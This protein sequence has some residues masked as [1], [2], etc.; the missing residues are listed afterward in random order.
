M[1]DLTPDP[2][3]TDKVTLAPGG[4]IDSVISSQ[5]S[6]LNLTGGFAPGTY[7]PTASSAINQTNNPTNS[8]STSI[9]VQIPNRSADLEAGN[10]LNGYIDVIYNI[11]LAM[12]S[13]SAVDQIRQSDVQ[14]VNVN[15]DQY[16]V[17]ASTAEAK[18]NSTS[19]FQ[20]GSLGDT[21]DLN[22]TG[23]YY[24]IEG[25]TFTSFLGHLPQN[26]IVA[27]IWD[28]LLKM[29]EPYGFSFREDIA[30]MAAQLG[31]PAELSPI[32]YVYRLE[33][34][35]SGYDPVSGN[36]TSR[37][38]IPCPQP[39]NDDNKIAS[40]SIVYYLVITTCEAKVTPT[41]T[42]YDLSFQTVGHYATRAEVI[43]LHQDNVPKG[44]TEIAAKTGETFRQFLQELANRLTQQVSFDTQHKLTI[45]YQF[46]GFK[47]LLDAK[48]IADASVNFSTGVT[49]NTDS[50]S[51][52]VAAKN[53][54]LYTLVNTVMGNLQ[55]VRDL[56]LRE[57]NPQFTEPGVTWN[58]RTNVK[59]ATS[60]DSTINSNKEYTLQ[61]IFEPVF[62]FR[63]RTVE[64]SQRNSQTTF[65][66]QQARANSIANYGMLLRIYDYYFTSDN[67]DIVDFQFKLKY[68]YYAPIPYP[69]AEVTLRGLGQFDANQMKPDFSQA[70]SEAS[71]NTRDITAPGL[72]FNPI[73]AG[74]G[75][76]ISSLL[77]I[78][79][80]P[81]SA[82]N[83]VNSSQIFQ[84]MHRS[85]ALPIGT[86]DT[87]AEKA[88]LKFNTGRDQYLRYDMV[89]A[90]MTIRFDPIWLMN[91]YMAG[92]D[93]TGQ[94]DIASQ[95]GAYVYAHTDHVIY[96]RAYR[97][98]QTSF[99][100]PD[101]SVSNIKAGPILGGFY[102]VITATNIFEGGKF[103]QQLNMMKYDHLNYYDSA[104]NTSGTGIA[105]FTT[106]NTNNATNTSGGGATGADPQAGGLV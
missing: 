35:F 47:D 90:Q 6:D 94:V 76:N 84:H 42:F 31:Y 89:N 18:T 105:E 3:L 37:I 28:G 57:D 106:N 78:A 82:G 75:G 8:Q 63:S 39:G 1:V 38:P 4:A 80:S 9:S 40:S 104:S 56:L 86:M 16:I 102:Q 46:V 85:P 92:K 66:S 45:N 64:I 91:P 68:F 70:N 97:P 29:F 27:V 96:I 50:G 74:G 77:G 48:F 101:Q 24:N 103:I 79:S 98:N 83:Q 14:S 32:D 25:M 93:Y 73:G 65:E 61:Y 10:V 55:I 43:I 52:A 2:T 5:A 21:N 72:T 34:W 15:P 53:V 23:D 81:T 12:V 26:P 88:A 95:D 33:V 49:F 13:K 44:G 67:T 59:Q 87:T 17:F 20:S 54:D 11:S 36:W 7:T 62:T 30:I 99:M 71:R 41:G 51:Y 60:P 22:Y 69:G 58:I 19:S 100:N